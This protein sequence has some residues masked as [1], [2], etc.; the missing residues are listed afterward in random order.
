MLAVNA[1]NA[2]LNPRVIQALDPI[3]QTVLGQHT[4]DFAYPVD[5]ALQS[6]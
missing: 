2:V 5:V 6:R 4:D 3:R 1:L